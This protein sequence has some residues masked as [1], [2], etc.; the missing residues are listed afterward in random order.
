MLANLNIWADVLAT[1]M[2]FVA[3]MFWILQI[4]GNILTG[5][6][7]QKF[8]YEQWPEH[9]E[10]IPVFPRLLHFAHILTIIALAVSGLYIRFPVYAGIKPL[11]Q[12]IHFYNMYLV[13]IIVV[14]RIIYAMFR[15]K[16]EFAVTRT[17]LKI[18]P[19]VLMYYLFLRKQ[20]PH[21]YRYNSLQKIIYGYI[22]PITLILMALTGFSMVWPKQMLGWLGGS[23]ETMLAYARVSHFFLAAT[24]ITMILVHICLSFVEDYPALLIFFGLRRQYWEEY[25]EQYYEDDE[26][27]DGDAGPALVEERTAAES[28]TK[29]PKKSG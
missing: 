7:K 8:R 5:R 17:D 14:V 29:K 26:Y 24:I 12:Q 19:Q 23:Q 22:F 18:I 10:I 11:M 4:V 16:H 13:I 28:A 15:D 1:G 9:D 25:E 27:F 3:V 20:Y 21:I 2:V 6:W